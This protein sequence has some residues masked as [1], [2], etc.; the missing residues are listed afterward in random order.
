MGCKVNGYCSDMTRTIFVGEP[1]YEQK[2]V[3]NLVLSSQKRVLNDIR[4]GANIKQLTKSVE[5]DFQ[6]K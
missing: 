4:E 6:I 5:S 2:K 3:Y 1:T